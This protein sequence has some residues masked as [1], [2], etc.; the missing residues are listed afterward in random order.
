[1]IIH[2]K[3]SLWLVVVFYFSVGQIPLKTD[4]VDSSE[5]RYQE[6][7]PWLNWKQM[8]QILQRCSTSSGFCGLI[9][10]SHMDSMYMRSTHHLRSKISNFTCTFTITGHYQEWSLRLNWKQMSQILQRCSAS[11]GSYIFVIRKI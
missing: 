9:Q 4:V 11:S 8:S 1:M 2:S 7:S 10:L 5:G 3:D 6:W